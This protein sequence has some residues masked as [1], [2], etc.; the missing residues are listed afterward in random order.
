SGGGGGSASGTAHGG[1]GPGSGGAAAGGGGA[2]GAAS[3]PTV[4]FPRTGITAD[5]LGVLV[6]DDDPLSVMIA[7]YYVHARKI[8]AKNVVHLQIPNT[9]ATT[10]AGSDFVPLKAQVDAAFMGT[11]VQAMAITWTRPYAVDNLSI[12][13]AFALGYKAIGDT[14]NDPN[15]QFATPNPYAMNM[16]STAPFTDLAFR[17]AM[18]I[19]ATTIDE[20]EAIIDR[21]VASDGTW[22]T[23]SAYL[24]DTSDQTRSARCILNPMYGW[25]NECQALLDEWDGAKTGVAA[26]IIDADE[27]TGKADVLF[28]VQGL[29]SVPDLDTNTYVPGAVA[30]HLTSFG[31]QIPTSAQM[32]AFEFLRAGATGS[33]GTVVEPCAFQ[34][35]FPDPAV[36]VPRYFGGATLIEAYWKSV[37]W[38]AEG[39]FIGEPLAR[40]WGPGYRSSFD[41]D[42]LTIETTAMVPGK[43]YVIEAADDANGPFTAVMSGLTVPAY[44]KATFTV[45]HANRA[46]Y[47]FGE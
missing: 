47:R 46:V 22:P 14:C 32:S 12:T 23:G 9:T 6:N 45:K 1:G 3:A 5:E 13:S 38:P 36:L 20:A 37:V 26:S 8:P 27:I 43:T 40:P 39:I 29:A 21:G 31:G 4:M 42:T 10:L 24:M 44:Q 2:G 16:D 7:D 11:N 33:Y 17:P 34:Q 28:Y 25:T 18:T 35:K 15:S 41:G 19:P 30:D